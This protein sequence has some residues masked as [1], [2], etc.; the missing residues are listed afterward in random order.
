M[1]SWNKVFWFL[2]ALCYKFLF[3]H[4]GNNCLIGKPLF[5]KGYRSITIE[6]K[7]RIFPQSRIEA[8]KSGEIYIKEDSSIGQNFHIVSSKERLVIGKSCLISANV[9]ISNCDHIF[10]TSELK[11][12]TTVIGDECFLGYGVVILPGTKLG[13]GCIVGANSVV[14]GV[15]EDYSVI[16]GNP[17]RLIRYNK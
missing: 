3:G 4:V 17:S 9:F 7:V 16:V 15:Y 11:E 6:N 2:R 1:I 12:Q 13:K 8:H 14:K 5:I 10:G